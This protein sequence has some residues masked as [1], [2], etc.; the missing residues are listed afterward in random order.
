V[1]A[2][3]TLKEDTL[4]VSWSLLT[5]V[6]PRA[7]PFHTTTE[8]LRKLPPFTV[9]TNP[10]APTVAL[11]G[12]IELTEG[13]GGQEQEAIG[14]RKIASAPQSA[15]LLMVAIGVHLRQIDGTAEWPGSRLERIV[16]A[17]GKL[18]NRI[19]VII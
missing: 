19:E 17:P 2:A 10:A 5:N 4:A 13:V 11:F 8:L 14:S 1:S 9:M 6:V 16:T 3:A 12:E 7:I 18:I 15:D